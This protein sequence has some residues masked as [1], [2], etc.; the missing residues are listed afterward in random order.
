MI[1]LIF[2]FVLI[3][4][5]MFIASSFSVLTTMFTGSTGHEEFWIFCVYMA[6]AFVGVAGIKAFGKYYV[7]HMMQKTGGKNNERL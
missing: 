2:D 3:V 4:I 7:R 1:K 6:L 5:A